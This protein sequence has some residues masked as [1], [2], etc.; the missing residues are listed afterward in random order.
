MPTK[1]KKKWTDSI[2]PEMNAFLTATTPSEREV[3]KDD[4]NVDKDLMEFWRDKKTDDVFL[5]GGEILEQEAHLFDTTDNDNNDLIDT[6][7]NDN[8][9]SNDN[10]CDGDIS[11]KRLATL[12]P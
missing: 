11:I 8:N 4:M 7:D 3:D 6:S 9:D 1:F 5:P 12:E 10:T 2:V